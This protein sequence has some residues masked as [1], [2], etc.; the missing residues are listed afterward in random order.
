MNT[1]DWVRQ[2]FRQQLAGLEV[3][4]RRLRMGAEASTQ[5]LIS[6][7]VEQ[8]VRRAVL[9]A[10]THERRPGDPDA[11]VTWRDCLMVA[12]LV[13]LRSVKMM[14]RSEM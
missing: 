2:F 14:A 8:T 12:A 1:I 9:D 4:A 3:E 11:E 6:H 7:L 13:E 10:T 5:H